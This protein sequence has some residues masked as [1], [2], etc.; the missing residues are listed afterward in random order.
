MDMPSQRRSNIRTEVNGISATAALQRHGWELSLGFPNGE[1]NPDIAK[2]LLNNLRETIASFGGGL[3]H[4]RVP[5]FQPEHTEVAEATGYSGERILVRLQRKL[6]LPWP[7]HVLPTREFVPGQ[8]DQ[9]WLETNNA[10]FAWHPEQ[11]NWGAT[12]LH[13]QMS[14]TW[15]DPKD[16]LLYPPNGPGNQIEGFCWTKLDQGTNPLKGEI[17]VIATHPNASGQG[18]GKKLVIAG[19]KHLY[20]SGAEEAYLYTESDN[21]PALRLY[22]SLDF[23]VE[24]KV[25]VYTQQIASAGS[26]DRDL[27]VSEE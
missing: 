14:E 26:T 10:A 16:F 2:E 1:F 4:W 23:N 15:F 7:P 18:L 13:Q 21:V 8:D 20:D 17:F 22:E 5:K 25:R 24:L 6:P 3:A 27:A 9:T 12:Q 19:L 11:S